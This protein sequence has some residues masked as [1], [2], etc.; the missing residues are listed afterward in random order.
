MVIKT[1]THWNFTVHQIWIFQLFNKRLSATMTAAPRDI[2]NSGTQ[3]NTRQKTK[4]NYKTTHTHTHTRISWLKSANG[5][6]F[7]CGRHQW[8]A[9][10]RNSV[11]H[12]FPNANQGS[13]KWRTPQTKWRTQANLEAESARIMQWILQHGHHIRSLVKTPQNS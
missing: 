9:R 5:N 3:Q 4:L 10:M 11:A 8:C 2:D 7:N 1:W 12:S 13:G 6:N